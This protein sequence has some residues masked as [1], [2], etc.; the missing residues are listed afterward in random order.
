VRVLPISYLSRVKTAKT[1]SRSRPFDWLAPPRKQEPPH[2]GVSG[3]S[4]DGVTGHGRSDCSAG[5][6][7]LTQLRSFQ[8]IQ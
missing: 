8:G 2:R 6:K 3:Q 4:P 1:T 7:A 5:A